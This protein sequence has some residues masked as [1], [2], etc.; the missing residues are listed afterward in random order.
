LWI[1]FIDKFRVAP[2]AFGT[3]EHNRAQLNTQKSRKHLAICERPISA[4]LT[5]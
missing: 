3:T 5:L 4:A 2:V 1:D